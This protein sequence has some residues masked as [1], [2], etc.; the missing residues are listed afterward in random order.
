[1]SKKVVTCTCYQEHGRRLITKPT[2]PSGSTETRKC[3]ISVKKTFGGATITVWTAFIQL[4]LTLFCQ[5]QET[6]FALTLRR[7]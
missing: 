1:M 3:P 2:W 7:A 5:Q 6:N 4:P